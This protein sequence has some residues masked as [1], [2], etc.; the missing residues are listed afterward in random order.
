[1]IIGKKRRCK[2]AARPMRSR[3]YGR[4]AASHRLHQLAKSTMTAAECCTTIAAKGDE[5]G[6]ENSGK[7]FRDR[8]RYRWDLHRCRLPWRR[9][10]SPAG[11]DPDDAAEP[12]RRG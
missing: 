2:R 7:Q 6:D 8:R 4:E 3:L 10:K 12:E 1:M 9:R 11:Q 5:A